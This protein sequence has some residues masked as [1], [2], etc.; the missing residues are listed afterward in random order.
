MYL[1]LTDPHFDKLKTSL[2]SWCADVRLDYPKSKGM[3]LTGDISVS[4]S[5]ENHLKDLAQHLSQ[6]IYF[7][8]GNH[9]Y[10]GSSFQQVDNLIKAL[11][12]N[13][14]LISLE[15]KFIKLT[16]DIALTGTSGWYDGFFGDMTTNV[17]MNDWKK[18]KEFENTSSIMD[19]CRDR[20][21]TL[22]M[23]VLE[24]IS[25]A[26]RKG[27]CQKVVVATH[28]PPFIELINR[29]IDEMPFYGSKCLGEA[30]TVGA[31][32]LDE[33]IVLCGHTHEKATFVLD[34][35]YG[36]CGAAKYGKPEITGVLDEQEFEVYLF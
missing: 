6:P 11:D 19:V 3:I 22:S 17:Q 27:R 31:T 2:Y 13:N 15:N 5:L 30:L 34:S 25:Q 32:T 7:V 24:N 26:Q 21:A 23:Q 20:A 8:L 16:E 14:G 33:M 9:D 10:W 29:E 12:G 36:Y 28:F 35:I 1:W 4:S 18:I